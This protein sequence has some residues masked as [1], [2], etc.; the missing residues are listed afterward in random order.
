MATAAR[1]PAKRA[2]G[3]SRKARADLVMPEAAYME[4]DEA[5]QQAELRMRLEQSLTRRIREAQQARESS[6][7]EEIWAEDE[8]QYNGVDALSAPAGVVKTRDQAPKRAKG[9]VRS[10]VFLNIT[11]PKTDTGIARVQEMLVPHDDKPWETKR[12]PVPDLDDAIARE[13]MTPVTLGDGTQAP[14]K[15]VAAAINAKADEL[16]KKEAT[17][18]EDKFVE[19]S[20]YAEMRKVIRSAGKLGSGIL[21]GPAPVQRTTKKWS[22]KNGMGVLE[23]LRKIEPT[24]KCISVWDFWPA[25]DCGDNIHNG[26]YVV[27]REWMT[28]R[29]LIELAA[30]PEYDQGNIAVALE[31]GPRKLGR[32][33][34]DIRREQAGDTFED[35][36]L[37]E[38][39]YIYA[40]LTP[41]DMLLLG[42][43]NGMP[44]GD[45]R[46]DHEERI[47][48]PMAAIATMLN[49]RC[50]RCVVNPLETGDFPYDLFPWDI[51]DGQPWGRG[52]PRK[53]GVAQRGL[54][55]AVRKQLENAGI[56]GG[57]QIVFTAGAV[58][59]VD[60]FYEITGRKLWKFDPTD[61]LTD[62]T[63]AFAV[64]NIPSMQEQL[65]AI[66][67]FWLE[68]ADL[69]TNLPILM[70]GMLKEGA[71]PETLGGM[72][73]LM[74]N[75]TS[76]LRVIAKQHDDYLIVGH[77]RRY[78]T[79]YMQ[80]PSIPAE[81]KGDTQ[82]A[83]RGATALVQRAEDSEFLVM[84]WASK[85]DPAL[86][87]NPSKLI[88]EI[89]RSRGFNLAT[90]QYTDD[91]W[92]QEEAKRAQQQPPVDPRV[93]AAQIRN[94]GIQLQV[95][96]RTSEAQADRDFKAQQAAEDRA[97][98]ER[99][100]AAELD[101]QAMELA[102]TQSIS[103]AQVK[104]MLAGKAMD[105]RLATDEMRFKLAP[106]NQ[107]GTGI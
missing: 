32:G 49:G 50:I 29:K 98:A 15:D 2:A 13:L 21:K 64:F 45:S 25:A 39:Y 40:Q 89:A 97:S 6:G 44:E 5:D 52:I 31:E 101:L 73:L 23:V 87:L 63:K 57:P 70:Q 38:V 68:M 93:Q 34:H 28:S 55:S 24:S 104:A 69:L 90:V 56:S 94:E 26:S 51:V 81:N 79:W 20:V 41:D 1:T 74:A 53:M 107:S 11:Q 36:E 76:P 96:A 7:I 9:G 67:Q 35:A 43:D 19:G 58:T 48:P 105:N 72:R 12:T 60:G 3:R 46:L 84:L 88:A 91:E 82:I 95:E 18:I 102:G 99:L 66:I 30:L 27:E 85:D 17:W 83:A 47:G 10:T 65:G 14:A 16:A 42:V 54:N 106:A 62:I 61:A 71:T 22:I 77:L 92:K 80:D 33:R 37:F 75:M 100:R 8:D 78:H 103:L 59:P 4:G 86:K